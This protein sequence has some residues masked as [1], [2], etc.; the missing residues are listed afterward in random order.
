MLNS[1]GFDYFSGF[2]PTNH[3]NHTNKKRTQK[4]TSYFFASIRARLKR[5]AKQCGQVFPGQQN[6][7][8]KFLINF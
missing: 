2:L 4:K 6:I 7:L 1:N 3:A 5:F 8:L